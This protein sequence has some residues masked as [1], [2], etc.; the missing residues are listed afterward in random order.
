MLKLISIVKKINLTLLACIAIGSGISFSL[1]NSLEDELNMLKKETES[2]RISILVN[3]YLN[4]AQES[5]FIEESFK[6][7]K[8]VYADFIVS[9]IEACVPAQIVFLNQSNNAVTYYWDFG[10][11]NYS[12]LENPVNV[13]TDTGKFSIK[14]I[15][16]DF[17]GRSDTLI[18]EK[19]VDIKCMD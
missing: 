14:L 19:G 6:F 4:E 1:F 17:V 10:D 13:Y 11:G 3:N 9:E 15:A 5:S 12:V 7:K 16:F 2:T 8:R 18:M